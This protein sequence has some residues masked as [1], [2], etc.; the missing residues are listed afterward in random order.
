MKY[1][2]DVYVAEA[3]DGP[4]VKKGRFHRG[5]AAPQILGQIHRNQV[6]RSGLGAEFGE[7]PVLALFSGLEEVHEPEAPGVR[8]HRG[9]AIVEEHKDPVMGAFVVALIAVRALQGPSARHAQMRE[10]CESPL[11]SNQEVLGT[12]VYSLD[13]PTSEHRL[14]SFRERES[15][16]RSAQVD[17]LDASAYEMIL[18]ASPD[19]L[20]LR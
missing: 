9:P 5:L 7:K 19:S 3:R 16:V 20:D 13:K 11:Q 10:P 8:E 1:F 12:P 15:E 18:E 2:A 17:L 4:L 6:I 14:E